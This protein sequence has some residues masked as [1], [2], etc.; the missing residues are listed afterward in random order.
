MFEAM[1]LLCYY[2]P[3]SQC[4]AQ[5]FCSEFCGSCRRGVQLMKV[6]S[7]AATGGKTKA[8]YTAAMAAWLK[9]NP[10]KPQTREE[11]LKHKPEYEKKAATATTSSHDSLSL[12]VAM[13]FL[14]TRQEIVKEPVAGDHM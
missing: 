5:G 14:A 7:I 2:C 13:D 1:R 10:G 11:F 9:A 4:G 3:I 8:Q 12:T 6:G